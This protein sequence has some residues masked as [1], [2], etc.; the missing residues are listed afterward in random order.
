ME[1]Q[2]S[3][4][5]KLFQQLSELSSRHVATGRRYTVPVTLSAVTVSAVTLSAVTLV[6]VTALTLAAV[7]LTLLHWPPLRCP[8]LH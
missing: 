3:N 5:Q 4:R 1:G 7:T 2:W 8:L 6:A